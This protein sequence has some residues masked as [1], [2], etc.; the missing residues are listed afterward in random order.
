MILSNISS[1]NFGSKDDSMSVHIDS[2]AK[3]SNKVYFSGKAFI[4][5]NCILG[6]FGFQHSSWDADEFAR[7]EEI[8]KT[9][10]GDNA[11]VLGNSEICSGSKIGRDFRCDYNCLVGENSKLGNNVVV[12]YG[13]RIYDN[14]NVKD[15]CTIGGFICNGSTVGAGSVVQGALVHART[16]PGLEDAPTIGENCLVGTNSTLVGAITMANSSVLAAG[17]VLLESTEEGYL[18]AGNPARRIKIATWY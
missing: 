1:R 2:S 10:I 5:P 15:N 18:Y 9:E 12:E 3:L 17:S 7:L 11:R 6:Y 4:G 16:L 8:K 14:C 13:A